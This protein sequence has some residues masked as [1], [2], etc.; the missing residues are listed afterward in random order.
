MEGEDIMMDITKGQ[1]MIAGV[2]AIVT[3]LMDAITLAMEILM[4]LARSC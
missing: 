4:Q 2:A 3:E 1:C